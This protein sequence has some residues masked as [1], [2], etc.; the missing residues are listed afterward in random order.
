MW[1]EPTLVIACFGLSPKPSL[2]Y[3]TRHTPE[4]NLR[5]VP[6]PARCCRNQLV[7]SS[8]GSLGSS[9]LIRSWTVLSRRQ[10]SS[11]NARPYYAV[12]ANPSP[13]VPSPI[14]MYWPSSTARCPRPRWA[15]LMAQ[16]R[17]SWGT[18]ERSSPGA[19]RSATDSD[20]R[21]RRAP[22]VS[23][24]IAVCDTSACSLRRNVHAGA[25]LS[26]IKNQASPSGDT[27]LIEHSAPPGR[28]HAQQLLKVANSRKT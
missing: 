6:T 11:R 21:D 23:D 10:T 1:K 19:G 17:R 9:A 18:R 24:K 8:C 2:P 15:R 4:G 14:G 7:H 3:V 13:E 16:K 28:L 26:A 27:A 5:R 12:K 25:S 20:G 22:F